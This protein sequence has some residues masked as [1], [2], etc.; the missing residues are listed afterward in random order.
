MTRKASEKPALMS[1][2]ELAGSVKI[3]PVQ[4]AGE[5]PCLARTGRPLRI[6]M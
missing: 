3:S 4:V 1:T 2:A 5:A 6:V